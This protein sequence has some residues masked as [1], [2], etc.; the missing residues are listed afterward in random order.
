MALSSPQVTWNN[1]TSELFVFGGYG[2][3]GSLM[4]V[5]KIKYH[6]SGAWDHQWTKAGTMR[7]QRDSGG[8]IYD[9]G[10]FVVIGG[11]KGHPNELWKST[12]EKK[13]L[14]ST[15]SMHSFTITRIE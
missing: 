3:E 15:E 9:N 7:V 5:Y 2:Q 10:K 11:F 12:L 13:L 4:N 14:E 6:G 8:I 1:D